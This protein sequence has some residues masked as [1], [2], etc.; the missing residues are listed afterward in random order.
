MLQLQE[1][2][3]GD[4]VFEVCG[5]R[6]VNLTIVSDECVFE[7]FEY[8]GEQFKRYILMAKTDEGFDVPLIQT[9]SLEYYGPKLY[10]RY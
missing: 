5:G 4:R 6:E 10:R 9:K 8:G 3:K 1:L 2:K 7:E